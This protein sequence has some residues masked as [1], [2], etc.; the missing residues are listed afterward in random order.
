MLGIFFKQKK[1][2]WRMLAL[3]WKTK[4]VVLLFMKNMAKD[5]IAAFE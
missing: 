3:K 1:G 5:M 4:M 2:Y